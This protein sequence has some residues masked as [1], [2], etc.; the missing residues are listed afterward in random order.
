MGIDTLTRLMRIPGNERV[1]GWIGNQVHGST[2]SAKGERVGNLRRIEKIA[3]WIGALSMVVGASVL[4]L[5]AGHFV[6][7]LIVWG[8]SLLEP[9]KVDAIQRLR[10]NPVFDAYVDKK[11]LLAETASSRK[12]RFEPYYHWRT[13]EIHGKYR[14]VGEDGVRHTVQGDVRP[15]AKKVFV[16]GGSTTWGANVPDQDTI[17]SYLQARLGGNFRVYNFG[18][19]GW[20]STQEFNYLL[21][22]LALGNVPDYV[23]FYDGAN[24]GFTGAYSP[25]IPRDP[26]NLRV[27][28][29]NAQRLTAWPRLIVDAY[30]RTNYKLFLDYVM[31][32]VGPSPKKRWDD[33]VASRVD[34][35]AQAVV[36]LYEAHMRQVKALAAE[37]GFKAFFFWQPNLFAGARRALPYE[38]QLIASASPMWVMSQQRVYQKA[39]TAFSGRESEGVLFLGDI[40]EDINEPIYVDWVHVGPRGNEIIGNEIARRLAAV[41]MK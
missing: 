19:T 2:T 36:D 30:D 8:K 29:K 3:S 35:N 1:G 6:L 37:Y 9:A 14:N 32:R 34:N 10:A 20:V 15:D 7:G 25:A 17:P 23:V 21:H 13:Q 16:L 40:F 22:Q 11:E 12:V 18:D 31:K 41:A 39:K 28:D 26:V 5:V 4:L 27:H 33:D 24:D 38:Q